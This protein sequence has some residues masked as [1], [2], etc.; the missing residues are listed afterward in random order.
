VVPEEDP[1]EEVDPE[2]E[3]DLDKKEMPGCLKLN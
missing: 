2:E 3:G 1:E